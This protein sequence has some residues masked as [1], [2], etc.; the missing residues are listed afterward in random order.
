MTFK[1]I[2]QI[3]YGTAWKE[4]RTPELVD[5]AIQKGFRAFDTANQPKHYQEDLVG[6]ALQEAFSKGLK[7]E[8]FFIQT[9]FTPQGGHDHRIP[10]SLDKQLPERVQES[11]A[12]SLRNLGVETLDSYLLHGPHSFPGLCKEDMEV[13]KSLEDIY[14]SGRTKSIGV[15]NVNMQQLETLCELS[16]V[17]PMVVQ[18]RC[19]ADR[20]WDQE[21]RD[22]CKQYS[23]LYQGF[24]LL[25]AN[26]SV[27][28]IRE[29][30]QLA[31]KYKV[32]IGQLIFRF[33]SQI[34]VIPLTGTT[35]PI[36]MEEDLKIF[37]FTLTEEEIHLIETCS[38]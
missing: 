14:K 13:W 37:E 20:A 7:R 5:L 29:I 6:Q 31:S 2:S 9:K 25:T 17:T 8:D 10:Y 33:S 24:S 4:D 11:F 27:Y 36:H 35:D 15:S 30:G 12:S 28:K 1:P 3:I 32:T 26:P 22:F 23:I 18:N 16:S 38:I 34:G 21:V 19:Y